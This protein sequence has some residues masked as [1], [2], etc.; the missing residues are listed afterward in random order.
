MPGNIFCFIFFDIVTVVAFTRAKYARVYFFFV[1]ICQCSE[2]NGNGITVHIQVCQELH[3]SFAG[4]DK[5]DGRKIEA[6]KDECL[7]FPNEFV[8]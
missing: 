4:F 2:A 6:E 7:V 5:K 1:C 8:C 3:Y